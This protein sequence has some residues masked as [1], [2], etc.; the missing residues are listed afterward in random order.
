MA[1]VQV[2]AAQR[3]VETE[4]QEIQKLQ[5]ELAKLYDA[6]RKYHEKKAENEGVLREFGFLDSG[7]MVYKLVGPV[8]AKQDQKEAKQTIEKRLS[9]I[10]KEM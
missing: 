2:T 7:S 6:R 9:Y 5:R 4:V 10:N 3:Q 1:K 8:L